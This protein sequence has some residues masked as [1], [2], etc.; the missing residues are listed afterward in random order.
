MVKK[1][2][3]TG[4]GLFAVFIYLLVE[5]RTPGDFSIYRQASADLFAGKN[6]YTSLYNQWYHYYYS[7]FFAILLYPAQYISLFAA[8]FIWLLLNVW[9][10]FR[11]VKIIAAYLSTDSFNKQKRL[12]FLI[13]SIVFA[14]RFL[15]D[16]I[17]LKQMT[18]CILYLSLEGMN[19]IGT[20]RKITGA[21]LIA[22]AINIK[23]LPL[24][25]LPYL[26][27]RRELKAFAFII[28]F[29]AAMMLLP[30]FV[31]GF[32]HNN[33]LLGS[34]LSLMNPMAAHNILD[35][36]E[37]SFHSLSTLLATLLVKN[38]PDHY[39]LPI[40]RNI[41]DISIAHLSL[42]LNITRLILIAFS[43]WFIRT[44]PFAA[45][46][47]KIHVFRE[48][49]YLLLLVPLIFPHQQ[50]Y[51]FLFVMPAV[52]FIFYFLISGYG[53]IPRLKFRL[54]AAG[55]IISYLACNL[56]LLLGE[57]NNYYDHFKI[58]TY[59]ALLLIPLL[60]A[61]VKGTGIES[62]FANRL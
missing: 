53:I 21:L 43:L 49:S 54:M 27:Y 36:D 6:I 61:T 26:L 14:L 25:L 41:A 16:N 31:I 40:R 37:R 1:R 10:I 17:H 50:Q 8:Q 57:Y 18:I 62:R 7:V 52:C 19:F 48:V 12:L 9:F 28:L 60:S 20:G 33:E 29:Y 22:L 47:G 4:L 5:A 46:P 2:F 59:G 24:V 42:I 58:L 23:L 45:A 39:A 38:V 15:H 34:W 3:L 35:V 44:R 56:S 11:M 51:A 30:V 13:L 55:C 32:R